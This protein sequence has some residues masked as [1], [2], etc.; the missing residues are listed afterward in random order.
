MFVDRVSAVSSGVLALH[1]GIE[2]TTY[3]HAL[4]CGVCVYTR[5]KKWVCMNTY[6]CIC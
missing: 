5:V 2:L 6:V 4:T 3:I 1:S